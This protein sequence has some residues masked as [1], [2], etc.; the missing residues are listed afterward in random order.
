MVGA[1]PCAM[2]DAA[3]WRTQWAS[4]FED[5][6]EVT[7]E[8]IR[9]WTWEAEQGGI[10]TLT[11]ER[12]IRLVV[13]KQRELGIV[14]ALFEPFRSGHPAGH[15]VARAAEDANRLAVLECYENVFR[16][17]AWGGGES[18]KLV[19]LVRP[20]VPAGVK[21]MAVFG[22]GAARF[23]LDAHRAFAPQRT[24]ALDINPLPLMIAE[25]LL[26][27]EILELDE[28][29]S[30]PL[31]AREAAVAT[32]L[33]CPER[34]GPGFQLVYA[35]AL[36]PP[37]VP[38]SLNAVLAPWFV[39]VCGADLR[40][41]LGVANRVLSPG[42]VFVQLGPLDF[43]TLLSRAYSFEECVEL[44]E[45]SG[46]VVT[47]STRTQL[48]NFDSPHS[49]ARRLDSVYLIVGKKIAQIDDV[50][51]SSGIAAWIEDPSLPVPQS[52]ALTTLGQRSML[53]AMV[54]GQVDGQ[55]SISDLA[56]MLAASTGID[57][58]DIVEELRVLFRKL[59]LA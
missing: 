12:L 27:G 31:G 50:R 5:Y 17:W 18:A 46:F 22:V 6:V 30:S 9:E 8:R 49:A 57:A 52:P 58:R 29:P 53:T 54:V 23:A 56:G 13:A 16:D 36:F 59:P 55:R 45:R 48:P 3:A 25:R 39:D 4:R 41:T 43:N 11:R 24:F 20:H 19:E 21:A 35:D 42:G 44:F 1:I 2:R 7:R 40:A 15:P 38:E 32:E 26:R 14:S 51:L 34:P 10:L 47:A 33:G 37:F 28:F